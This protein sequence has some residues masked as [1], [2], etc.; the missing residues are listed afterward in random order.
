MTSKI[1]L[2]LLL[3]LA[4]AA[5]RKQDIEPEPVGEAVPHES[6]PDKTWQQ[7]LAVSSYTYFREAWQRSGMD[8][9]VKQD[10]AGFYTLIVPTDKAFAEAG[11]TLEKI[12]AADVTLLDELLSCYIMPARLLPENIT[13]VKGS[14][15]AA[16]L[17]SRSFADR[18]NWYNDYVDFQF[19]AKSGDSLIVNGVALSKWGQQLEG[20]NGV[21]Y[22]IDHLISKP[23][24]SMW[25][26]LQSQPRF[27]LYVAALLVND[28]LY[29]SIWMNSSLP[30]LKSS[31][32]LAQ[33]T[34]FAPNN[35]A[36]IKNGF[37]NAD[38]I[39]QYCLRS[40]PLPSPGYDEN[41]YWQQPVTAMDSILMAC[42]PEIANASQLTGIEARVGPVFFSND[43]TLNAAQLSGLMLFKGQPYNNPPTQISL[44]FINN[45]GQPGVRRIGTNY[46]YISLKS[47][48]IRVINGVVHEVGDLFKQ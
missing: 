32:S 41:M 5:C 2:L 6:G 42:G 25:E 15:P 40:W 31:S 9:K 18:E 30:L 35:D 29:Q 12:K 8:Q 20:T 14:T 23:Q 37:H 48:D 27:S 36:F 11:W 13:A 1:S 28:S 26:Y 38:D 7:Q 24:Q 3:L 33:F 10:G 17:S 47:R 4:F 16:T 46:P 45:N 44:S 43:L 34:L 21:I 22:P 19:L 39:L